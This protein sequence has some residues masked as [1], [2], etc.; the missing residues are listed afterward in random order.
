MILTSLRKKLLDKELRIQVSKGKVAARVEKVRIL[1][2]YIRVLKDRA[3]GRGVEV[4]SDLT[5]ESSSLQHQ[6]QMGKLE[7]IISKLQN[8]VES[9]DL[10][11]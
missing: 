7:V 4:S 2:E 3:K 11:I 1:K 8:E 10:R 6:L 5:M 9:K